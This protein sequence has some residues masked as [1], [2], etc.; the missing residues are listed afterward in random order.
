MLTIGEKE[1]KSGTLAIRTLDGTVKYGIS[2]EEFL[3]RVH[4][5][6]RLRKLNPDI[7]AD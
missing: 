3:N 4:T 5:H 7:F 1:S 6:I 2:H